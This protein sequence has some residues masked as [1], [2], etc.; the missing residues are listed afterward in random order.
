M[1]QRIRRCSRFGVVGLDEFP[2]IHLYNLVGYSVSDSREMR[3]TGADKNLISH[4][5]VYSGTRH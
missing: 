4:A 5:C 2:F 3:H 1:M